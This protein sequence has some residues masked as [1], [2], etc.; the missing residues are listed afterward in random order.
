MSN[1][2]NLDRIS[3]LTEYTDDLRGVQGYHDLAFRGQGNIDWKLYPSIARDDLIPRASRFNERHDAEREMFEEFKR[4]A[5]NHLPTRSGRSDLELLAIAQHHGLPTRLLDWTR[6][7]LVALWFA[8]E[9][10][11][12]VDAQTGNI[13]DGAVFVTVIPKGSMLSRSD[14]PFFGGPAKF[15]SPDH[16]DARFVAQAGLFSVHGSWDQ[17]AAGHQNGFMPITSRTFGFSSFLTTIP[18]A[19]EAFGMI[20][21]ELRVCGITA[22]TIF[23]DLDGI[24]RDVAWRAFT[25]D[26]QDTKFDSDNSL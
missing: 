11:P 19:H 25:K 20:R 12:C 16:T 22:S 9:K 18:I 4:A 5:A 10:Q 3:T 15:F 8:V 26:A 6:S 17:T 1:S 23:P 13:N 2:R 24:C 7:A 14:T 21:D